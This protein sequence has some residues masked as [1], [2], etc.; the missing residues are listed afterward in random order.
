MAI[1]LVFSIM[2]SP[3]IDL[4]YLMPVIPLIFCSLIYM[5]YDILKD[6]MKPEETFLILLI[7][8]IS[9]A[10][11]VIPKLSNNSYTYKGQGKA[12][13]YLESDINNKPMVYIYEDF[14]AQYNKT[15]ECYEALTKVDRT[16]IM[17]K[18]KFSPNNVK[19]ILKDVKSDNGVFVMMHCRYQNQMIGDLLENDIFSTVKYIGYLGRFVIYE[20]K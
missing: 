15:M 1:Y 4:R 2:C 10:I 16:Y 19:N 11:S 9:F 12:L 20:L 14:S 7:V 3:Y 18:E 17:S 6:I 13:E 5:I 8:S